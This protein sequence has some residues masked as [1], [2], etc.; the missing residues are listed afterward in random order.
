MRWTANLLALGSALGL[1]L[2]AHAGA[3]DGLPGGPTLPRRGLL[4]QPQGLDD[5]ERAAFFH[6]PQG[7]EVVPLSW[8]RALRDPRTKKPFTEDL[9][10]FG[11]LPDPESADGL[12]VGVTAAVPQD[13]SSAWM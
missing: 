9:G 12:P 5:C 13:P 2:A 3:D 4:E 8:L 7:A 10:R 11:F 1:A 6:L